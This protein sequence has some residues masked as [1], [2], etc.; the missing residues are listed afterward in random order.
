MC[1]RRLDEP[2]GATLA[3]VLVNLSLLVHFVPIIE[4]HSINILSMNCNRGAKG[5]VQGLR[6]W[7]K[8][9]GET[10]ETPETHLKGKGCR[11]VGEP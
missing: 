3:F 7:G 2:P 11:R 1:T 9:V 4:V 10:R 8:P 6:V 5:H